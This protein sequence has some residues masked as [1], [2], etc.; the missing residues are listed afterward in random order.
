MLGIRDAQTDPRLHHLPASAGVTSVEQAA[1]N[2]VGVLLHPMPV[3]DLLAVADADAVMP[4]KS[5]SFE[6]KARSGVILRLLDDG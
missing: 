6:P 5:T 4:P 3:S 1:G 2:G